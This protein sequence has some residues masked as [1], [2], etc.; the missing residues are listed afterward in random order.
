MMLQNF[1][2]GDGK[3]KVTRIS[4]KQDTK[5]RPTGLNTVNLLKVRTCVSSFVNTICFR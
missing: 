3:L 1:V 5:G 4:E 2:K